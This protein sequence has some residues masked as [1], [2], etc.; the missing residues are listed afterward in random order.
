[1]KY[2]VP[3]ALVVMVVATFSTASWAGD[4][5][6]PDSKGNS[7][8]QAGDKG[9]PDS[10]GNSFGQAGDKGKPDNKGNSFGKAGDGNPKYALNRR[11]TTADSA[12]TIRV[13]TAAMTMTKT[14]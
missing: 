10:K 11:M 7:F 1:M 12:M 14:V 4:K 13:I 5:G 6:K 9:K 2:W 8:E 3:I